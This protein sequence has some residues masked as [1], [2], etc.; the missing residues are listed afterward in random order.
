MPFDGLARV[1]FVTN[2]ESMLMPPRMLSNIGLMMIFFGLRFLINLAWQLEHY[3]SR[4]KNHGACGS[5]W[6]KL[7]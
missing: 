2:V 6:I 3:I 7:K 4:R 1:M 5:L